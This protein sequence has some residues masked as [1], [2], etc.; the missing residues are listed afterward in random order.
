MTSDLYDYLSHGLS[1]GFVPF[2]VRTDVEQAK[3]LRSEARRLRAEARDLVAKARKLDGR[4]SDSK[5]EN[6]GA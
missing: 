3:F 4:S 2:I 5:G 1:G 6:D